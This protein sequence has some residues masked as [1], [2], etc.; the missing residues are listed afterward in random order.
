[1]GCVDWQCKTDSDAHQPHKTAGKCDEAT[2]EDPNSPGWYLVAQCEAQGQRSCEEAI[3]D[4]YSE[5]PSGGHY[6]VIMGKPAKS[7][8]Y[9]AL[10]YSGTYH[11]WWTHDFFDHEGSIIV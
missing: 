8:T 9:K 4:Y 11:I 3:D 2:W 6:Q 5:G 7:M 1:M 10:N